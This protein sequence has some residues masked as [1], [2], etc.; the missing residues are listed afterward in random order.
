MTRLRTFGI[1]FVV[2]A[3]GAWASIA[4]QQAGGQPP[5]RPSAAPRRAQPAMDGERARR[6]YVSNK[7]E[8]NSL[9]YNFERDVETKKRTDARFAEASKGVLDF[10]KVSYRTSVGDL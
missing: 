3:G 6:L 9:G 10:Q 1:V 2:V 4:G 5:P 7:P 8:D